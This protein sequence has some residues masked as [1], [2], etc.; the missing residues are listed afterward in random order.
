MTPGISGFAFPF[1]IDPTTGGAKT[2][3]DDKL[4]SNIVHILMTNVGERVM[5]RS[6]G[7]G[8]RR[9]VQEANDNALW[10]VVQHQIGKSIGLL[11][12]RVLIQRLTVSQSDDGGTLFV[13]M[14][15]V[16]RRTQAVQTLTVPIDHLG[17]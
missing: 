12:P 11:E 5:R 9:L 3:S 17:L 16:V 7:G 13:S 15:Y 14:D 2:E 1:Q 8:L 10:A 4:R 6:Y